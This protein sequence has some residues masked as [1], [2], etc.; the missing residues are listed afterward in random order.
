MVFTTLAPII[1]P[2]GAII[3]AVISDMYYIDGKVDR[4]V[5]ISRGKNQPHYLPLSDCES[6]NEKY[7]SGDTIYQLANEYRISEETV[8]RHLDGRCSHKK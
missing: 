8:E 6:I 5:E 3:G 4:V 1:G 7:A 2:T